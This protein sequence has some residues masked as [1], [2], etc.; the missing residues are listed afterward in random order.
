MQKR[1]GVMITCTSW[2]GFSCGTRGRVNA[3]ASCAPSCCCH[4]RV[5]PP[6][7]MSGGGSGISSS[8]SNPMHVAQ[9]NL[10][11]KRGASQ[12]AEHTS[13]NLYCRAEQNGPGAVDEQIGD[14]MMQVAVLLLNLQRQ[15]VSK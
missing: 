3:R 12:T 9:E 8:F 6:W 11:T 1:H 4:Y 7:H 14:L 5:F 13:L 15:E 10:S 2:R